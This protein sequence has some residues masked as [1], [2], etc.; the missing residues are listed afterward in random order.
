MRDRREY[1]RLHSDRTARDGAA[2][3]DETST[4]EQFINPFFSALGWDV[5][6]QASQG[7]AREVIFHRRLIEEP[8]VAGLDEWDEDLTAE[9]L[10]ERAQSRGFLITRYRLIG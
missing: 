3:A 6:D 1:A 10:A 8:G 2:T 9:E 5:L 4:R 7:A